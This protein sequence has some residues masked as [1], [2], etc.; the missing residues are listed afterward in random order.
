MNHQKQTAP[1]LRPLLIGLCIGVVACTLLLLLAALLFRSVD[2]PPDAAAPV[3]VSAAAI[4][5]FLSGLIAARVAGSRG[6]L[7]GG[8]CGLLLFL[9]LLLL[10]LARGGVDSGYAVVKLAAL[11]LA[12]AIGGV[13]GVNRKRR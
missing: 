13:L 12:G 3:A 2:V 7:T 10:G 9:V 4:S 11:T 8:A 5:A 1:I 6:L